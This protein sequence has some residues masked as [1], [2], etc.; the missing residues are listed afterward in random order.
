MIISFFVYVHPSI[1]GSRL[2][3]TQFIAR[4]TMRTHNQPTGILQFFVIGKTVYH[5]VFFGCHTIGNTVENLQRINVKRNFV[6]TVKV[7][8]PVHVILR[9]NT[10]RNLSPCR[11]RLCQ[12][13]DRN[14]HLPA[15]SLHYSL[16][17]FRIKGNQ[18][19]CRCFGVFQITLEKG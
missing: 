2:Q 16:S 6:H 8:S 5:P 11:E 18:R 17:S 13:S 10:G 4:Q 19:S 9:Y 1:I 14:K 15:V 7:G 3:Q 12:L